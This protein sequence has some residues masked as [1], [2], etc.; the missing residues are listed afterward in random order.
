MDF[1]Y[2]RRTTGRKLRAFEPSATM[3][4]VLIGSQSAV[5]LTGPGES[6]RRP[7]VPAEVGF[8]ASLLV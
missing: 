5:H 6:W 3:A 1:V 2:D 7:T 4:A 8:S